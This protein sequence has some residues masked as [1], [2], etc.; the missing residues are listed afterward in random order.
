MIFS[1]G[2]FSGSLDLF[3]QLIS[4]VKKDISDDLELLKKKKQEVL[5]ILFGHGIVR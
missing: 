2:F 3:F 5:I 1:L 4:Y